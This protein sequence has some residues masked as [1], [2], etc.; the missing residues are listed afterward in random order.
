[1]FLP[2]HKRLSSTK[3]AFS[4][5]G[6]SFPIFLITFVQS[7]LGN[8]TVWKTT[9]RHRF[10]EFDTFLT[11]FAMFI[12]IA[13]LFTCIWCTCCGHEDSLLSLDQRRFVFYQDA[14]KRASMNRSSNGRK[15][16]RFRRNKEPLPPVTWI[17]RLW[18][19]IRWKYDSYIALY[20][21]QTR[22]L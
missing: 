13:G 6:I 17:W 5:F 21:F 22:F 19:R 12:C 3:N 16:K 14:K 9:L 7:C 15:R 20:F 4:S 10:T 1:M 8:F 11:S 18:I 2:F